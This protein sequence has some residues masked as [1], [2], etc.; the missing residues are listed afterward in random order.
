MSDADDSGF[1]LEVDRFRSWALEDGQ[2]TAE[3]ASEYREWQAIWDAFRRFVDLKAPASWDAEQWRDVLYAI[4]RDFE[5]GVLVDDLVERHPDVLIEIAARALKDGEIDARLQLAEGL[6]RVDFDHDACEALLL[7]YRD[8]DEEVVRRYALTALGSM[9]SRQTERIALEE[10]DRLHDE[11]ATT[12]R[13]LRASRI[14][15]VLYALHRVRARS[16]ERVLP[17]RPIRAPRCRITPLT[18][19]AGSPTG[20]K[21]R[22]CHGFN[23]QK[24]R[25]AN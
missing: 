11:Q 21:A 19:A 3:W 13:S 15:A 17:A 16:F 10:W 24:R 9:G 25:G 2:E 14:A 22:W 20:A 1:R 6:G 5:D 7:A 18:C 12:P 23:H 8:D 4:A